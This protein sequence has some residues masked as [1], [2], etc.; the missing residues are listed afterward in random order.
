MKCERC[1]VNES[2]EN[3]KLCEECAI[4]ILLLAKVFGLDRIE[5]KK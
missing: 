5:K 1:K 4:E 3:S 2:E